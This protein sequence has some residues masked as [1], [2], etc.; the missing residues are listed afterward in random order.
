LSPRANVGQGTPVNP[1]SELQTLL[2]ALADQ[3]QRPK[4]KKPP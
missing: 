1:L 2:N 3:G 4:V